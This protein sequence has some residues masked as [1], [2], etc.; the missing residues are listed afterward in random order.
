MWTNPRMSEESLNMFYEV[1][2]RPIYVGK[3]R[4]LNDFFLNQVQ[5]GKNI[6]KFV[7]QHVTT[8]SEQKLKVFDIGC[9]AGGTLVTFLESGWSAFGCDIGE[10]YLRRGI[11]EGLVLEYGDVVTL[12]KYGPANLIILSHVLE[13][14]PYPLLSLQQIAQVLLDDGYIYI[15]L[16]GIFSIHK[17]YGD[18]MLFLQM[19]TC[20]ILH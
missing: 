15:E 1:D 4:A 10:E 20:I 14:F 18:T 19:P 17:T 13:H 8:Y 12:A 5:H 2:Y 11:D 7:T 9:G 6:Y 16:P 3:T